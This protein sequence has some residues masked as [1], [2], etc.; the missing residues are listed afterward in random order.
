MG[1]KDNE[2]GS[3]VDLQRSATEVWIY[4][5]REDVKS[6]QRD[7]DE[8][9]DQ[10][11]GMQLQLS[12]MD[13]KLDRISKILDDSKDLWSVA[14]LLGPKGALLVGCLAAWGIYKA[15]EAVAFP[16]APVEVRDVQQP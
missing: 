6:L 7:V 10:I 8:H 14:R 3:S 13:G 5:L 16:P 12:S 2:E 11:R 4:R 9:D 1:R 15:G